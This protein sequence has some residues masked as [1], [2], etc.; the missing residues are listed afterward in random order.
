MSGVRL[1]EAYRPVAS[2]GWSLQLY[3]SLNQRGV[4]APRPVEDWRL[5]LLE[6]EEVRKVFFGSYH[7]GLRFREN[8]LSDKLPDSF[9]EPQVVAVSGLTVVSKGRA[10]ILKVIPNQALIEE[11]NSLDTALRGHSGRKMNPDFQF[12]VVVGRFSP[13]A[14]RLASLKS[15]SKVPSEIT[16]HPGQIK[17]VVPPVS[18]KH[19]RYRNL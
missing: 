14:S 9:T 16:L 18:T 13:G 4:S 7:K 8:L 6:P 15:R 2:D 3:E 19:L 5:A 10:L 17:I 12:S 11:R 1:G